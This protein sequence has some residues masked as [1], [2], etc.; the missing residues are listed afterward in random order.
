MKKS[1]DVVIIG[2][3][4]IGCAIAYFLSRQLK[5]VVLLE[6]KGIATEASGANYGMIWV[7]TRQS[8]YDITAAKR[9]LELYPGLVSEVF[10]TDIEYEQKGGMTV[11]FTELERKETTS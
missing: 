5:N 6:G 2:G 8:G 11:F 4:M 7:Q 10:D 1:A 9:S 3:G